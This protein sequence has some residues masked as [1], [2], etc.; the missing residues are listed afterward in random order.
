MK[1]KILIYGRLLIAVAVLILC[2]LAYLAHI[3]PAKI[4]DWQLTAALQS[5]LIFGLGIG[6]ILF[7]VVLILTLIFGRVYCSTLCPL[8][9]YQEF[10]T[11]LFKPFYQKR[12]NKPQI[13]Y[14]TAYFLMAVMFGSLFGGTVVCLRMIDPYSV[15]GNALSSSW[16]GLGFIVALTVLVFFKQRFFCTNICPVGAILGLISRFSWLKI[17]IDSDKCTKCGLCARSCP[18]RSIDCENHRVNNETCVKCF[19]CLSHCHNSSLYYGLPKTEKIAFSAKRRQFIVSGL[20]LATFGAAF[21]GGAELAKIISTKTKKVILPAGGSKPEIFANRCLNCNLCVKSCPMK[22]IKPAT[23]E[24][25]FVHLDYNEDF[26]DFN[27][28]KCS[29]VCPSGAIKRISLL[30]KKKTKIATAVVN[31]D[32]C[33]QCGLCAHTCPRQIIIKKE[34]AFPVIRYDEC[35]GCGMCASVC[36]VKAIEIEPVLEQ[37]VLH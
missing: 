32:V 20:V 7:L 23:T 5:G 34:N 10:L 4:F 2:G 33:V 24:I 16:F 3:Y 9:L 31:N 12:K 1:N 26:C 8:G 22:I 21:K 11:I 29:E 25:P 37:L 17:R 6:L 15:A 30:Q 36:P 18:C 27:C 19:K 14:I 13:H 28:H 35:I